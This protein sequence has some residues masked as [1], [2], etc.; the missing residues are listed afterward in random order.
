MEYTKDVIFDVKY[1]NDISTVKLKRKRVIKKIIGLINQNRFVTIVMIGL[2][3]LIVVDILL[4][5]TFMNLLI[6]F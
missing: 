6:G 3:S 5:N 1:T 4:V 2:I